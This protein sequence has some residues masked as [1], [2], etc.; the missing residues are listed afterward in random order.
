M[1][2]SFIGL[3]ASGKENS[4]LVFEFRIVGFEFQGLLQMGNGLI[5][6]AAA[7]QYNAKVAVGLRGVRL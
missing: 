2:N 4:K 7:G 3:P 1:G 6:L 5:Y